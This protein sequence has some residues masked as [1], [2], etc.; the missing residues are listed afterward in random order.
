MDL[1]CITK[2]LGCGTIHKYT[3]I[4]NFYSVKYYKHFTPHKS[5]LHTHN[6]SSTECE[7]RFLKAVGKLCLSFLRI[8][9]LGGKLLKILMPA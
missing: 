1:E 6:N 2:T 8:F 7:C 4:H 5:C 9:T 3:D